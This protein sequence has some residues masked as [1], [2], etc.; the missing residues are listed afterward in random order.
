MSTEAEL[1]VIRYHLPNINQIVVIMDSIH[2]AKRIFDLS[3]YPYQLHSS[4]IS[5]ELR[6]FFERDNNNSIE[7]QDCPSYCKWSLHNI[8]DKETKKF[9]LTPI[10][11]CKSLWDFSRKNECNNI[12][13][14]W[15]MFFQVS[16][17]KECH[18]LELLDDDLKP[19]EPLT[20]RGEL[21]LKYFGHS[22]SLCAR[23]IRATVNHAPIDEYHLRFFPQ[24]EFKCSCGLYSIE[25]RHYILHKCK[26]VTNFIQLV[27][28]QPVD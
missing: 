7:F 28:P 25:S 3:L 16:D 22:N 6:D 8:V 9:D 4:A 26:S 23:A 2:V 1:F 14:S 20:S 13:H 24:E 17:N 15:K 27:S 19:I 12:L 10:F 5:C 11:S 21:Q 18:F